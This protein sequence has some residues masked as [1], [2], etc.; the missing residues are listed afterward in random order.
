MAN[1]IELIQERFPIEETDTFVSMNINVK[2]HDNGMIHINGVPLRSRH[3]PMLSG[4]RLILQALEELAS[5]FR[6]RDARK[7]PSEIDL[8]RLMRE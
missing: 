4:S 8:L 6:K 5:Q 7:A 2:M 1:S 3:N